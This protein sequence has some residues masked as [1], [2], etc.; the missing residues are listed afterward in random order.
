[1]EPEIKK[2]MASCS[3][4]VWAKDGY[5]WG[6]EDREGSDCSGSVHYGLVGAGFIRPARLTADGYFKEYFTKD[7]TEDNIQNMDEIMAVFYVAVKDWNKLDG[8]PM[9]AGSCRHVTPVIGRYVVLHADW[10]KDAL[11]PA[12]A[13]YVREVYEGINC[14]ALWRKLDWTK[15]AR[16]V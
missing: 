11:Y 10:H 12:T 14:K 5:E 6:R 3:Q 8:T 9:L 1:M 4:L 16:S 2:Y 7:V 15:L 13:K